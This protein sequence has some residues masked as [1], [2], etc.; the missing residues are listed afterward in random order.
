VK[1]EQLAVTDFTDHACVAARTGPVTVTAN[2]SPFSPNPVKVNSTATSS[3]SASYNP[4]SGVSEGDLTPQYDWSISVQYK[5]LQADTFGSP[6]A[7][8]YTDTITPTQ[9]AAS[10]SA[11]LSFTPLIAGYWQVS[12][13]CGVTVTDT[14]TNQYW[15]GSANAGPEDL[16]SVQVTFSPKNGSTAFTNTEYYVNVTYA[17]TD[18]TATLNI[19]GGATFAAGAMSEA[20]TSAS[21]DVYFYGPNVYSSGGPGSGQI[22]VTVSP[23]SGGNTPANGA[24]SAR[25]SSAAA[26]GGSLTFK[27]GVD[28]FNFSDPWSQALKNTM[29][30]LA[31]SGVNIIMPDLET[32]TNNYLNN[33]KATT[34]PGSPQ[35]VGANNY[36]NYLN[37]TDDGYGTLASSLQTFLSDMA[38]GSAN[39]SVP[40]QIDVLNEP[41]PGPTLVMPGFPA[42]AAKGISVAPTISATFKYPVISSSG[43]WQEPKLGDLVTNFG[44]SATGPITDDTLVP[45][46]G[47]WTA[48]VSASLTAGHNF[49]LEGGSYTASVGFDVDL[50]NNKNVQLAMQGTGTFSPENGNI[51]N[52]VSGQVLLGVA[53]K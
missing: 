52:D 13:S 8:S 39:A 33:L 1:L 36:Y 11:T 26:G 29:S 46:S 47:N 44:I 2:M 38:T 7:N 17:P 34:A 18:L 43:Q 31:Q 20:M 42:S 35:N 6:P 37:G 4:P 12:A 5:A 32:N 40:P 10:S 49:T 9:P 53:V 41:P 19:S 24:M 48:S 27:V 14:K 28:L 45:I 21:E 16:T 3:L 51:T 15:T 22:T 30:A 25:E 50:F 23:P